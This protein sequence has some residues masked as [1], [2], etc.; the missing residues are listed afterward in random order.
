VETAATLVPSEVTPAVLVVWEVSPVV[1]LARGSV[2]VHVHRSR[3]VGPPTVVAL[4]TTVVLRVQRL[5]DWR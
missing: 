1:P 5:L 3:P 2:P 4:H